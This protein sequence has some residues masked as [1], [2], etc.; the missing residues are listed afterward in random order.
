[1]V[2]SQPFQRFG[3]FARKKPLKR[4]VREQMLQTATQLKQGV[5]EKDAINM[6]LPRSLDTLL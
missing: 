5:N 3:S 2:S 4:L 1:M 6:P